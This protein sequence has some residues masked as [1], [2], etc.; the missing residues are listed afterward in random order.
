MPSA[1]ARPGSMEV[2]RSRG[3]TGAN[4]SVGQAKRR[5]EFERQCLADYLAS[6]AGIA[7]PNCAA[8]GLEVV[9]LFTAI[10]TFAEPGMPAGPRFICGQCLTEWDN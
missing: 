5:Q 3:I 1:S 6:V 4:R 10:P 9:D 8:V 7:C 2:S